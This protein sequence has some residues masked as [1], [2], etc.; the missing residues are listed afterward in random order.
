MKRLFAAVLA[1]V[2]LLAVGC[3]GGGAPKAVAPESK[4]D[5]GDVPTTAEM[6]HHTFQIANEGTGDLKITGVQVKL[7]K[8][9]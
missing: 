3:S 1:V 4:F 8:G 5:F 2:A 7:L 6:K 9:C